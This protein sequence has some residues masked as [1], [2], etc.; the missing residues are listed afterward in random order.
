MK[1]IIYIS[2]KPLE[3]WDFFVPTGPEKTAQGNFSLVILHREQ[4]LTN[5]PIS[6][7][8]YLNENQKSHDIGNSL[9]EISYQ[10]FLEQ[11]FSHD[12]PVV[13]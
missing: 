11:I 10:G 9:N 8:W 6:Q 12:L 7:V 4:D 2:T 1:K 3:N 13:I 5:A